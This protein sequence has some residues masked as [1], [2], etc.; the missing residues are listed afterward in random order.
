MKHLASLK[1]SSSRQVTQTSSSENIIIKKTRNWRTLVI[2]CNSAP[3]KRAELE[4]LIDYTEPDVLILTETKIDSTVSA[5]N[6]C[7]R[8][9]LEM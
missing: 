7:P 3:G 1:S 2:N 9:M 6:F 5:P 4:N 8:D